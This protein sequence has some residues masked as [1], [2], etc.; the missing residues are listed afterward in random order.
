MTNQTEEKRSL[1]AEFVSLFFVKRKKQKKK[2]RK[3]RKNNNNEKFNESCNASSLLRL[4][5]FVSPCNAPVSWG[6]LCDNKKNGC[7]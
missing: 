5:S 3:Q 6:A 7:L 2:Q 1:N 4:P